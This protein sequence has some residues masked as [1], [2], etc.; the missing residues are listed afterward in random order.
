MRFKQCSLKTSSCEK[1][2]GKAKNASFVFNFFGCCR[3][4][5]LL[6]RALVLMMLVLLSVPGAVLNIP[7]GLV[8]RV[9]AIREARKALLKS[10]VKV[11]SV[12]HLPLFFFLNFALKKRSKRKM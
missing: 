4:V 6:L 9:L 11:L 10:E 2:G 1:I 7:M 3:Y 8:S 12:L 5:T